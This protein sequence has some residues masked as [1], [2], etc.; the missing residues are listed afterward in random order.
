[1]SR[2]GHRAALLDADGESGIDVVTSNDKLRITL[3]ETGTEI[4]IKS[5]GTI[6]IEGTGDISIKSSANV[7]VEASGNLTLKGGAGVK[8][9]G[10][11]VDIDGTPITLN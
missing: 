10:A 1:V 7:S 3:D 4:R 9:E 6:V 5:D 11:T 8:I 2:K